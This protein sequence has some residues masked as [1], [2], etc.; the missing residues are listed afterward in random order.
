V[1]APGDFAVALTGF[2]LLTAWRTPPLAVVIVS[3]I[4]GVLLALINS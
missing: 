4:G 3:A 2:V 1:Q